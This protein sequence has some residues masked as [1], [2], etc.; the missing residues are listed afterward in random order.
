MPRTN[1]ELKRL[2]KAQLIEEV[3]RLE[4]LVET[5]FVE[6]DEGTD[7]G[8]DEMLAERVDELLSQMQHVGGVAATAAQLAWLK[9]AL[10]S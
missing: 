2:N 1:P 4:D 5:E 3:Q 10:T 9:E 8:I 7:E 6:T